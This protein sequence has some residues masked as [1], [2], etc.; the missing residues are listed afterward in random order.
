MAQF[1][2]LSILVTQVHLFFSHLK[3]DTDTLRFPSQYFNYPAIHDMML[4]RSGAVSL[5]QCCIV[6]CTFS[7]TNSAHN[8]CSSPL[9][10]PVEIPIR[11]VTLAPIRNIKSSDHLMRRGA[12]LSVGSPPQNFALDIAP[13]VLLKFSGSPKVLL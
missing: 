11:N 13:C 6:F 12:A 1:S 3:E 9:K 10:P 5:L 4:R 8:S 2:Y 7:S